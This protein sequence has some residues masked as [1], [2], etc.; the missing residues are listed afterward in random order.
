MLCFGRYTSEYH[1]D[2]KTVL[3]IRNTE[4]FS[5]EQQ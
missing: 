4:M 5:L 3:W 2:L 1:N